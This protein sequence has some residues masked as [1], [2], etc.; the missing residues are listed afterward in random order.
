MAPYVFLGSAH[1]WIFFG[2]AGLAGWRKKRLPGNK[3]CVR[4]H[5]KEWPVKPKKRLKFKEEQIRAMR[6]LADS[7]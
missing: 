4:G 1:L 5:G 2:V 3:F 7:A 6:Q